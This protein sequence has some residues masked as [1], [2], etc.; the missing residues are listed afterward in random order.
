MSSRGKCF[1]EMENGSVFL[2][3]E[4]FLKLQL[5]LKLNHN[6]FKGIYLNS[7]YYYKVI[8]YRHL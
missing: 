6:Y 2:C 1:G 4:S 7:N 8:I 5:K 3:Q